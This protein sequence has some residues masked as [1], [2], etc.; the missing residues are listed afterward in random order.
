MPN[1][2]RP[3]SRWHHWLQTDGVL[4]KDVLGFVSTSKDGKKVSFS[5]YA[6][7]ISSEPRK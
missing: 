5:R 6:N 2:R 4:T 3:A 1:R 7:S